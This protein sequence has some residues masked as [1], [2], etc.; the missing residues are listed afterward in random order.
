[1]KAQETYIPKTVPVESLVKSYQSGV[2]E[3]DIDRVAETAI[4]AGGLARLLASIEGK[5]KGIVASMVRENF[6]EIA[7]NPEAMTAYTAVIV[8]AVPEEAYASAL[9][10]YASA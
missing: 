4:A 8:G 3:G 2:E 1:M 10:A 5:G 9:E 7:K 6:E